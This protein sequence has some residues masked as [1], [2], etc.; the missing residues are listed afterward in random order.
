MVKN[1]ITTSIRKEI[2]ENFND[3]DQKFNNDQIIEILKQ[4]ELIDSL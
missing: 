1:P 4:H 3:A 2:F